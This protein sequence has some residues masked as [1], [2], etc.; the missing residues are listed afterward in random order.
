MEGICPPSECVISGDTYHRLSKSE[1]FFLLGDRTFKGID[2]PV[3]VY[4][5]RRRKPT[6]HRP[7]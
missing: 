2:R 5:T 1:G 6:I 3:P 4:Q 7:L